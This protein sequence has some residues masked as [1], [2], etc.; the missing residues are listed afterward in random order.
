MKG[1]IRNFGSLPEDYPHFEAELQAMDD[2]AL[3]EEREITAEGGFPHA[4][5]LHEVVLSELA[6]RDGDRQ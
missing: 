4:S 6:R 2:E 3:E 1:S 5:Q